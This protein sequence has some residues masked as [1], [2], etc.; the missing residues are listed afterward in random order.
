M[1][2]NLKHQIHKL[3]STSYHKIGHS[4]THY[5]HLVASGC[6]SVSLSCSCSNFWKPWLRKLN[7]WSAGTV[8]EY[9][10]QIRISRSWSRSRSYKHN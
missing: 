9:L 3:L 10:G 1:A 6:H 5:Y 7:F 8:S 4:H 2:F